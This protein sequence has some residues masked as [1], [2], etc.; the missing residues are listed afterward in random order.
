[1]LRGTTAVVTGGGGFV[2]RRLCARLVE[3]G[4]SEVRAFDIA[5]PTSKPEPFPR[6]ITIKGDVCDMSAVLQ[7]LEGSHVVFHVAGYGMS[8][9]E[10]MRPEQTREVNVGGTENVLRACLERSVAAMV[11]TSTYNVVFGG[12]PIVDG[13]ERLPYFSAARHVDEY[14]RSKT[15]A[16]E[17][18]MRARSVC[19]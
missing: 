13:D 18:V 12:Y 7:C 1:M 14:G 6:W 9:H 19:Q 16:E 15:L 8:G 4:C 3:E 2:G 10:M 17:G 5:F 11:L